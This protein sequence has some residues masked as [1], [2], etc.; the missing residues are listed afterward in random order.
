MEAD[1]TRPCYTVERLDGQTIRA[2]IDSGATMSLV[3]SDLIPNVP[4][5]APT[6]TITSICGTQ[7][8]LLL[9]KIQVT[10]LDAVIE[11]EVLA[12]DRFPVD[13]LVGCNCPGFQDILK[14]AE[15]EHHIRAVTIR[16]AKQDSDD[17]EDESDMLDILGAE[18]DFPQS[19]LWLEAENSGEEEAAEKQALAKAQCEDPSLTPLFKQ[20]TDN[21]PEFAVKDGILMRKV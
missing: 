16:Q 1:N 19:N 18:C 3:W 15:G 11:L 5:S 10:L 2:Q 4:Q 20:A 13:L 9:V 14:K 17:S 6:R 12:Y 7:L 21:S 8:T